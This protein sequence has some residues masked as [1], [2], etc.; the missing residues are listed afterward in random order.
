MSKRQNKVIRRLKA[1][2]T[3]LN[4]TVE[5]KVIDWT[6]QDNNSG[7]TVPD[8]ITTT[9]NTYLAFLR[10]AQAGT[11]GDNRIGNKVT[12]MSQTFRGTIRAP[13]GTLDE[14]QNHVR[15]LIVENLGYTGL[16]DLS[17]EDVLQFGSVALYGSQV[18]MSPYK[19]NAAENK[20]YRVHLDKTIALNKTDR[21]YVDFKK[22]VVY[23]TK[24]DRGKVL[25]FGGPLES[26]PNNHRMV[27]F[28][29]SDSAVTGHPDITW[30]VR[31][32]YKDA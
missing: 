6:S 13:S 11:D 15:L 31:S 27:M 17:L 19:T 22:R 18:F 3:M 10:N 28:V 23:G 24:S 25:T 2:E 21:G 1:V 5:N 30:N 29:I 12:L 26:F 20:R 7:S 16:S 9:G 32:I 14:Q 8:S 4:K